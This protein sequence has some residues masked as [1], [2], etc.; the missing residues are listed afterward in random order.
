LN[1]TNNQSSLIFDSD[2]TYKY[3]IIENKSLDPIVAS[4]T[5]SSIRKRQA[6][7]LI[8]KINIGE[9]SFISTDLDQ[10]TQFDFTNKMKRQS[11]YTIRLF[12]QMLAQ[13]QSDATNANIVPS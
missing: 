11:S 7:N 6:E 2:D 9:I 12:G 3:L 10:V 5:T 4:A 13:G 8:R 1:I